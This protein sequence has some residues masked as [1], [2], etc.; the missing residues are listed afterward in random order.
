MYYAPLGLMKEPLWTYLYQHLAPAGAFKP[1]IRMNSKIGQLLIKAPGAT[2]FYSCEF[3]QTEIRRHQ[4][5]I[6]KITKLSPEELDELK[7]LVTRK[8][9]FINETLLDEDVLNQAEALVEDIDPDDAPFLAL[10]IQLNG[11]LWTG[12][13]KLRDGLRSKGFLEVLN[14]E[15]VGEWLVSLEEE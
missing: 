8:I 2:V 12:D 3:L 6:A 15:E 9:R 10:A 11:K 14:T 4:P 7:S 1:M 5:K 13:K